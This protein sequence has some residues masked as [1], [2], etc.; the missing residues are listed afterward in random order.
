MIREH[1]APFTSDR[2]ETS[3]IDAPC[4]LCTPKETVAVVNNAIFVDNS[5]GTKNQTLSL[6][7]RNSVIAINEKWSEHCQ[8]THVIATHTANTVF[9]FDL[10]P[11]QNYLLWPR[12]VRIFI[13]SPHTKRCQADTHTFPAF[14]PNQFGLRKFCGRFCVPTWRANIMNKPFIIYLDEDERERKREREKYGGH[15]KSRTHELN[16]EHREKRTEAK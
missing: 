11:E 9:A 6:G 2:S 13:V 4:I 1:F 12:I 3:S 7:S 10:W 8:H 15:P 16:A 5:Y 14:H